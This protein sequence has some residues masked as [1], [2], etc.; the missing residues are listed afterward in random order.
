MGAAQAVV[1]AQVEALLRISCRQLWVKTCDNFRQIA[2]WTCDEWQQ[3]GF[4]LLLL[5]GSPA[6]VRLLVLIAPFREADK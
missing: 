5:Q 4:E 6:R 2:E 3:M 1:T